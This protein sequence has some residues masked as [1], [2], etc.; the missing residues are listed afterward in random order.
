M[1]KNKFPLEKIIS[2]GQT[3]ADQA[4]LRAAK[5]LGL[6]TGGTAPKNYRTLNGSNWSLR[7]EYGLKE[8]TYWQYPPRTEANICDS[9]GT[10]R[11]ATDFKSAGELLT[12]RLCKRFKKPIISIDLKTISEWNILMFQGW[13]IDANIVTLNVAGN[14]ET[15][16][17]GIGD[18]V[19]QFL[20]DALNEE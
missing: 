16:S 19:V 8:S 5:I 11:F 18:R 13:L 10:V 20:L 15:T 12:L 7:D 3:G 2:G 4:G 9:D 6:K 1:N 14:S 17:P